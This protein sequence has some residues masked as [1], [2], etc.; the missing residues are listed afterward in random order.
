MGLALNRCFTQFCEASILC[1]SFIFFNNFQKRR[2]RRKDGFGNQQQKDLIYFLFPSFFVVKFSAGVLVFIFFSKNYTS[3]GYADLS[4]VLCAIAQKTVH[5]SVLLKYFLEL[6]L[7]FHSR[8]LCVSLEPN[9]QSN[10]HKSLE[11]LVKLLA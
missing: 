3:I 9:L 6:G 4:S 5:K 8:K 11:V 10:L 7:V 2:R 1:R